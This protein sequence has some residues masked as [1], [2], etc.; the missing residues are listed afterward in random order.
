LCGCYIQSVTWRD[1]YKHTAF[2]NKVLR[3]NVGLMCVGH[4][5]H[6][7]V[8]RLMWTLCV[9]HAWRDYKYKNILIPTTQSE[10]SDWHTEEK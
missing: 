5:S 8:I 1:K 2:Q 4:I 10:K 6:I 7:V 9:Q 3:I